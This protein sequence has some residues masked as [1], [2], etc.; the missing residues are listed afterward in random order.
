[1]TVPE[2]CEK[3]L[4]K[5]LRATQRI[6]KQR[7]ENVKAF[8]EIIKPACLHDRGIRVCATAEKVMMNISIPNWVEW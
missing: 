5:R 4:T 8:S 1:M 7:A 3:C 6:P 2:L